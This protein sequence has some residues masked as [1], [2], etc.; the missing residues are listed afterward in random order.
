MYESLQEYPVKFLSAL[1]KVFPETEPVYR[2]ECMHLTMLRNDLLSFQAAFRGPNRVQQR[3]R[4]R[5]TS[6]IRELMRVRVVKTVPVSL[7]CHPLVDDNYLRTTPGMYPDLLAEPEEDGVF[8]RSGQWQSLWID[9]ETG[10][11]MPAGTYPV[12]LELLDEEGKV[13]GGAQ[14]RVEVLNACLPEQKLIH[15][16]W[17]HTDCL[18]DYYGVEPYSERHWEIIRN[19]VKTAVERGV[20]MI[21]TPVFT[22]PLDTQVGGE[23]TT[24]QLVDVFVKDGRYSFGFDRLKRWM[25]LCTECGVRY[26]EISHL[27]TQWGAKAA[28]KV[29]ATADGE[30]RRIFG[31]DTPAVGGEYTRF[32]ASFLPALTAKLRAWG[33]AERSYFHI[34]DEP[35]ADELESYLAAKN[36]VARFLEGFHMIDALSSYDFYE[37]GAV[38]KPVPSSD[39]IA[40][41]IDH[42]VP[43]LWVYYCTAQYLKVSNRFISMPSARN[44]IIGVQLFKYDIEG[45]LHWGYNFYNSQN[46]LHK[47][48]PF[49]TT[50][51]EGAFP[52]GDPFLVYPGV[53]G[54]PLESIRLMVFQQALLDLQALEC[55]ASLKGKEYVMQLAEGGL[56]EPLTFDSYPKSDLYLLALRDRVNHEIAAAV[57]A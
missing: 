24:V 49:A 15:T 51:C 19:F 17:F 41:F 20:N 5:L 25:D 16:E 30:Y 57:R 39:H 47:I 1:E 6:P 3:L 29:M 35:G 45:F 54:R 36:S 40:P 31:W 14:T 34:S 4:Y 10:K 43:G 38:S 7:A 37:R 18:A 11:D 13:L 8:L 46:S 21:L 22:P 56:G 53:D 32:L 55:L 44:R 27:F 23:R 9:V 28:P 50:D 26:F 2:P 12:R 52:A 48:D 42:R 33:I